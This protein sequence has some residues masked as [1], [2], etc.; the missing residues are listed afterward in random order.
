MYSVKFFKYDKEG[1]ETETGVECP[2]YSIYNNNNGLITVTTYPT[3]SDEGG[4]ERHVAS[5]ELQRDA[6]KSLCY[7]NICFIENEKGKTI[8]HIKQPK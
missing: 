7:Y 3:M 2:H 8:Q 1:A 5:V 6:L 4:V